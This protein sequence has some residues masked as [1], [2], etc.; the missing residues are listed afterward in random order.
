LRRSSDPTSSEGLTYEAELLHHVRGNGFVLG[1][2]IFL[3]RDGNPNV[4][5]GGVGWTLFH[6]AGDGPRVHRQSLTSERTGYA[7]MALADLHLAAA[8]FNPSVARGDSPVF[9]APE[10]WADRW[11]SRATL[12]ADNLGAK[13]VEFLSFVQRT[14]EELDS[15]NVR[16]LPRTACHGDYRPANLRF[17]YDNV[18]TV[19]DFDVAFKSSQLLDLGGASTRFSLQGGAPSADVEA[20]S[21]FLRSYNAQFPLDESEWEALPALI[22][23][24]L[25]RDIVV[26]FDRWWD[27][28]GATCRALF[29][30]AAEEIVTAARR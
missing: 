5:S 19:F 4:W 11:M 23:W 14:V 18:A 12:L 22:R 26:Y 7:A 10:D 28:V 15:L 21:I 30:G 2:E 13:G 25:I 8:D 1:P 9:A 6:W 3:A 27:H 16:D 20:G 24:R 29:G 17:E